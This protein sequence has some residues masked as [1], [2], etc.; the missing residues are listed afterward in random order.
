MDKIVPILQIQCSNCG[1]RSR[2]YKIEYAYEVEQRADE[3]IKAG[4]N[5]YGSVVYCPACVKTWEER[6][7]KD[8]HMAGGM[9]TKSIV[10]EKAMENM[11][12]IIEQLQDDEV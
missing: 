8:K 7:G 1:H 10:I 4:W 3:M 9:N 6:N 12:G 11:F 5:S 2:K